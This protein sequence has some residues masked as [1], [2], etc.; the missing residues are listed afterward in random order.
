MISLSAYH[1]DSMGWRKLQW[2]K[3]NKEPRT[4]RSGALLC[5]I[6]FVFRKTELLVRTVDKEVNILL[7]FNVTLEIII[8]NS[9]SN[10]LDV[11]TRL[12]SSNC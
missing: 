5:L 1:D 12:L 4:F 10:S 6:Q 3:Y 8:L 11:E 2:G 9:Y 7:K